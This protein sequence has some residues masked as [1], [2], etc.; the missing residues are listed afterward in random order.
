MIAISCGWYAER[1]TVSLAWVLISCVVVLLWIVVDRRYQK[2]YRYYAV[3]TAIITWG[4]VLWFGQLGDISLSVIVLYAVVLVTILL[5]WMLW[6]V[7]R[8]TIPL[9]ILIAMGLLMMVP[10]VPQ[11]FSPTTITDRLP[12]L[13]IYWSRQVDDESLSVI[14]TE[15]TRAMRSDQWTSIGADQLMIEYAA[16][17]S[18]ENYVV[19]QFNTLTTLAL[20]P[21]SVLLLEYDE[22]SRSGALEGQ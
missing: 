15:G 16:I 9:L 6:P 7:R 2:P 3:S 12:L 13:Q 21:Q 11:F 22:Y 14:T 18:H 5:S 4:S 10:W 20:S 1:P 19:I 17:Q 8:W